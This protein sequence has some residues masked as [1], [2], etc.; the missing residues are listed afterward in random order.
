ML[1]GVRR[2]YDCRVS[3]DEGDMYRNGARA[4]SARFDA[5]AYEGDDGREAFRTDFENYDAD[6]DGYLSEDE[7]TEDWIDVN[8]FEHSDVND[9]GLI[10]IGEAEDGF[11]EWSDGEDKAIDDV[12]YDDE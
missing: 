10:D 4:D 2:H 3:A 7:A 11:M 5:T 8:L 12:E 9:D 1:N 6:G